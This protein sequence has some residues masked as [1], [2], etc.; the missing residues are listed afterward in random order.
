M[1]ARFH[2]P[3]AFK[4]APGLDRREALRRMTLSYIEH[5][6]TNAPVHTWDAH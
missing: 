1:I 4:L 3:L 2:K 6:H 5:M